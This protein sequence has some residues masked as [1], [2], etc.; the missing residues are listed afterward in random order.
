MPVIDRVI[1]ISVQPAA[2]FCALEDAARRHHVPMTAV[3]SHARQQ[4]DE[5]AT[6]SNAWAPPAQICLSGAFGGVAFPLLAAAY[7]SGASSL[8]DVPR[9]AGTILASAT[10]GAAAVAAFGAKATRP[11]RRALVEAIRPLPSGQI[12]LTAVCLA[13]MA[14]EVLDP[15]RLARVLGCD[16]VAH[17]SAQLP[18]PSTLR[19]YRVVLSSWGPVRTER[20]LVEAAALEGGLAMLLDTVRYALQLGDHGPPHPLPNRLGDLRDAH[21]ALMRTSPAPRPP[22][23]MAPAAAAVP[24]FEPAPPVRPPHPVLAPRRSRGRVGPESPLAVPATF[25]ALDG[26][27]AGE[28]SFVIPRTVGDLQRWGRLLSNC[29]GDFGASAAAGRCFLLGVLRERRLTYVVELTPAGTIRQFCGSANRRPAEHDRRAV[30]DALL[31][32]G[33]LDPDA[34]ANRVWLSGV[35]ARVAWQRAD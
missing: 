30:I 3:E 11:V 28:L 16:R 27:A 2:A 29:L 4:L 22:R 25:G 35:P 19:S 1:D 10:I 18:D 17:A 33:V 5:A 26:R 9:W 20:L 12:D 24:A 13:L 15:D 21:R 34:P 8:G 32:A 6:R 14:L 23:V 31:T 7:D